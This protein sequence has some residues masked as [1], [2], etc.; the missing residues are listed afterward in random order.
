MITFI[1]W[2]NTQ[3]IT[4]FWN[5]VEHNWKGCILRRYGNH[6]VIDVICQGQIIPDWPF[7]WIHTRANS[8]NYSLFSIFYIIKSKIII[9]F[10]VFWI[11]HVISHAHS[12]KLNIIHTFSDVK[13]Q[14]HTITNNMININSLLGIRYILC[15]FLTQIVL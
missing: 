13:I 11:F 15:N 4:F 3:T 2:I 6:K 8:R 7:T 1:I 14:S 9:S 10:I 5:Y 12:Y